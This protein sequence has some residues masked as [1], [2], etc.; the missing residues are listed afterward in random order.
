MLALRNPLRPIVNPH[1]D[2]DSWVDAPTIL[3]PTVLGALVF[4]GTKYAAGGSTGTAV[5]L[6][7]GSA[8]L[9]ILGTHAACGRCYAQGFDHGRTS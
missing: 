1:D 3:F 2:D 8:V 6:G 9:G 7:L 5:V 4:A